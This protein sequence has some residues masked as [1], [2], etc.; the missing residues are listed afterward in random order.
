MQMSAE[1]AHGAIIT[2]Q[3]LDAGIIIHQ[4]SAR[5]HRIAL[6]V[7]GAGAT[8]TTLDAGALLQMKHAGMR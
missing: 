6:F 5:K 8:A 3:R 7:I 4:V 2:A 1:D